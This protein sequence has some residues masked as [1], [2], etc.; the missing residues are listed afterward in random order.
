MTPLQHVLVRRVPLGHARQAPL[1]SHGAIA[2]ALQVVA[3]AAAV[4]VVFEH[5]HGRGRQQCQQAGFVRLDGL[6]GGF[7]QPHSGPHLQVALGA[8]MARTEAKT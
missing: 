7:I 5:I 2:L 8:R 3:V 6:A 1:S 4:A